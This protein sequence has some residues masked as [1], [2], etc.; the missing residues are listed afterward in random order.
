MKLLQRT[1]NNQLTI[2]R[3]IIQ[4]GL[5]LVFTVG[6]SLTI[7]I[8]YGNSYQP[9]T[10]DVIDSNKTQSF[11][12]DSIVKTIFKFAEP[13]FNIHS[14]DSIIVLKGKPQYLFKEQWGISQD[15]LL[16]FGYPSLTF[17]FLKIANSNRGDLESIYLLDK[18]ITLPGNI[19]IGKTTRQDILQ[20]LGLPDS[21]HND[22][23]RSMTKSED[24]TVYWTKSG[25]GDTVNFSYSINI[26]EYAIGFAMTKD[27]LCKVW[28]VKNMN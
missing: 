2:K 13:Y 20:R 25:V 22:V 6:L 8:S 26:D 16:T 24:T 3:K 5:I 28:W 4:I 23:G 21:D 17:N 12:H 15:S 7:F 10:S 19:T 11:N 9:K 1:M 18:Y 27:T 14:I